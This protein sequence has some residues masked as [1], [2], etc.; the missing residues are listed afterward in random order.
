MDVS[1]ILEK[2]REIEASN[3]SLSSTIIRK[4]KIIEDL[5]NQ[6]KFQQQQMQELEAEMT[7]NQINFESLGKL[8]YK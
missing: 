8:L 5:R 4:K 1:A 3:R 2:R 7:A 6:I